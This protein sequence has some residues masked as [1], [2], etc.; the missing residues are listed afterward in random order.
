[1]FSLK[2]SSLTLKQLLEIINNF[3]QNQELTKMKVYLSSSPENGEN[4]L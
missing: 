2:H 3:I 1:M 4:L